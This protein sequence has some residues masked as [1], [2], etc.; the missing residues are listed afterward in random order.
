M[1]T[2]RSLHLE[3]EENSWP[4]RC[5]TILTK[6]V[7]WSFLIVGR[8][9]EGVL[10]VIGQHSG[11]R[12]DEPVTETAG[13]TGVLTGTVCHRATPHHACDPFLRGIL[14]RIPPYHTPIIGLRIRRSQVRVLPSAPSKVL[15]LQH[16]RKRGTFFIRSSPAPYHNVYHNRNQEGFANIFPKRPIA[17]RCMWGIT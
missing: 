8:F 7:L 9:E 15:R 12:V 5:P 4:T 13:L 16:K 1:C 11:E 10:T 17:P 3:M 6:A 2:N 14:R